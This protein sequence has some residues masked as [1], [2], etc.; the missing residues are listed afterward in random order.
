[1]DDADLQTLFLTLTDIPQNTIQ[2]I[3]TEHQKNPDKRE[4]QQLLASLNWR[5]A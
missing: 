3:L 1:M 5:I 2:E 4:A